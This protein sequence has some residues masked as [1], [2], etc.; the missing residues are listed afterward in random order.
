M[1]PPPK[2][3]PPNIPAALEGEQYEL[4]E[5]DAQP[6]PNQI[7]AAQPKY[8]A[9]KCRRCDTMMY[10]TTNQVGQSIGCPDCGT[11]NIVPPPPQPI[12]KRSVL[13]SDAATPILDPAAHPGERPLVMAPVGKMVH[14]EE[15]EAEYA[16]AL[17]K[18]QPHRQADGQSTAAEGPFF[19]AGR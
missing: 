17:A 5:P 11:K 18:S 3:K 10:A 16:R 8:I 12:V 13:S 6:L 15:Q 4:W 2:P 19:R 9:M 7:V 1:P 14:E